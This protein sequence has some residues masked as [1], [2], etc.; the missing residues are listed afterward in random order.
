[1]KQ[2]M[3]DLM[4]LGEILLVS[5]QLYT[6]TFTFRYFVA[7]LELVYNIYIHFTE[8]VLFYTFHGPGTSRKRN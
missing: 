3:A 5:D 7:T 8:Q 6:F 4:Y 1:M 2:S